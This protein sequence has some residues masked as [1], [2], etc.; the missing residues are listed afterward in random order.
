MLK[1][2]FWGKGYATEFLR[3]WLE[4]YEKLPRDEVE[5]SVDPRSVV[6]VPAGGGEEDKDEEG[7]QGPEE[8]DRQDVIHK[9]FLRLAPYV[10]T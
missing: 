7:G 8:D 4:E 5:L 10:I 3:A 1:R 2:E 6:P 9:G